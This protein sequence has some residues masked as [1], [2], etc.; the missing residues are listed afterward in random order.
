MRSLKGVGGEPID[1]F[2]L[3]I[4]FTRWNNDDANVFPE[5]IAHQYPFAPKVYLFH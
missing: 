1:I 2:L 5:A 3:P 4:V